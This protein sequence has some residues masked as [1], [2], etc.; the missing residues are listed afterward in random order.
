MN[1]NASLLEKIVLGALNS[2]GYEIITDADVDIPIY[3]ALA[4]CLEA[5]EPALS[6][7]WFEPHENLYKD[8]VVSA[9]V[10]ALVSGA[11]LVY[12]STVSYV[13]DMI[14]NAYDDIKHN[15][16]PSYIGDMM[17][18][19]YNYIINNVYPSYI[20]YV[21]NYGYIIEEYTGC[22]STV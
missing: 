16:S 22:N 14:N 3:M 4:I 15:I 18:S 2:L 9:G 11:V 21:A 13:G 19:S 8:V 5:S 6:H 10:G 12:I 7:I 1:N 20:G 17:N